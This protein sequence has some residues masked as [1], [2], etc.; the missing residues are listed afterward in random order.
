MNDPLSDKEKLLKY[1]IQVGID[2]YGLLQAGRKWP[3]DGGHFTRAKLPIVFAGYML[4]NSDMINVGSL[5]SWGTFQ[6]DCNWFYTQDN[7]PYAELSHSCYSPLPIAYKTAGGYARFGSRA[8]GGYRTG[9]TDTMGENLSCVTGDV[10]TYWTTNLGSQR[11][12]AIALELLGLKS[13]W[14]NNAF[15][16][17]MHWTWFEGI[18]QVHGVTFNDNMYG[19]YHN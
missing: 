9:D 12:N 18:G 3:T 1:M 15:F 13:A 11:G 16:D 10:R 2:Y 7:P 17:H 8:C 4:G 14:N 6:E 5:R 19:Q